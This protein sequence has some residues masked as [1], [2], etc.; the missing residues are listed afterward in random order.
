MMK[1]KDAGLFYQNK[2]D[3][4]ENLLKQLKSRKSS[5]AWLRLGSIAAIILVIY[6]LIQM[7]ILY[8]VLAVGILLIVFL[9]LVQ[10][11]L[12]NLE[13]IRYTKTIISLFQKE[14][15]GLKGEYPFDNGEIYKDKNHLYTHD[16]DIFGENSL[17]Q[18]L[19]RT[20]SEPGSDTLANYLKS[21]STIDEIN[22][23]QTGIRE[24]GLDPE[25]IKKMQT[26]GTI[27]KFTNTSK[28]R[29]IKWAGESAKF[30]NFKPW[31]IIRYLLPA[32]SVSVTVLYLSDFISLGTWLIVLLLM[33]VLVWQ[34]DKAI[35]PVH[36][37][38]D[39]ISKQAGPLYHLLE[40]IENR[41]FDSSILISEQKKLFGEGEK[42]S[43]GVRRIKKLLDRLD[44][45][46]NWVVSIPLN[47]LLLWDL[48]QILD[49]E[50][51]KSDQKSSVIQWINVLS[52]FEALSSLAIFHFNNPDYTFPEV[53]NDYFSLN[54][55]NV[56]HPLILKA[57][58]V[59]NPVS[60]PSLGKLMLVTGSNMA[61]KS[62]YLRSVG[63][64]CV[65]AFCGAPVCA[66]RFQVSLISV[67]SSMRIEDNLQESTST[68]Y[69]ELKKLK[70]VIDHVNKHDKVLVLLD[71]ILRGTNSMDRHTGSKAL[72]RQMIEQQ[73]AGIIATHDLE[74]A[75]LKDDF[76]DSIL[77]FHFDVQVSDE[78]L[79]FDYKLKPGIC[80]SMNA[81]ILMKKIGI[82]IQ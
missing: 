12:Q 64:N 40:M 10:S 36:R 70:V 33:A 5:F 4:Y 3:E 65:L 43:S 61:G 27:E 44:L 68:F 56:G 13:K 34:I 78:E 19:N 28:D 25:W 67:I 52:E 23:R 72:I 9:R 7:G 66:S 75:R 42:A 14:I 1:E 80:K 11:D 29:L 46:Y 41:T 53:T 50:K 62:T 48:Q 63:I 81:S 16:L 59:N 20:T 17:F 18:Y 54:G 58:R 30:I 45:R 71:E 82:E 38:L 51:W 26:F 76:A 49:L 69:A 74:L 60:L 24:L 8:V 47:L 2:I 15:A 32:I 77:N 37:S 31:K 79:F 22:Q 73:T 39:E 57:K 21:K 6:L 55:E 35:A